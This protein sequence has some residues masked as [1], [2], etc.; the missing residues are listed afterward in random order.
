MPHSIDIVSS[1]TST[2]VLVIIGTK[3]QLHLFDIKK[4][5]NIPDLEW[6]TIINRTNGGLRGQVLTTFVGT[7]RL[8]VV[9]L[10]H[11]YSRHNSPSCAWAIPSLLRSIGGADIGIISLAE[12]DQ[13]AATAYAVARAFPLFNKKTSEKRKETIQLLFKNG[14]SSFPIQ[15]G[16]NAVRQAAKYTEMP[17]NLFGVQEFID[18]AKRISDQ[19]GATLEIIQGEEL[20]NRGFGGVWNVGKAAKEPPALIIL[21]WTPDTFQRSIAIV[22][23]GIIY[24][25]GGLSLK[26]KTGMPGMKR[27]MAG[28]AV[29]LSVFEAAI[30]LDCSHKLTAILA[31]AENAI[32][33]KA[34]RPDDIIT[35]YSGKTVEINN[36]DAEGRL[37]LADGVAFAAQDIK[38][39]EIID[40]ATLTGASAVAIGKNMGAMCSNSEHLEQIFIDLSK[41]AGEPL[42]PIPYAPKLFK[43]EFNSSIADMKNSVK[44]RANAQASCAAQFIANHLPATQP[45]WL[46]ID[47]SGPTKVGGRATGFGTGALL[48]F[49]LKR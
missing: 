27:D 6:N 47:M 49:I 2:D 19:F 14:Q 36:T 3:A 1:I 30:Q 43:L 5:I 4:Q 16:L 38:A 42:F 18:E 31:V 44:D 23:K 22:G 45:Q 11:S 37:V 10:P 39:T 15:V 33:P 46:H 9:T 8:F 20:K 26:S 21:S 35:M 34:L 24:D 41:Q 7:R 32:G 48:H 13:I 40:I 25:T 28:A 12:P 17:T 29:V